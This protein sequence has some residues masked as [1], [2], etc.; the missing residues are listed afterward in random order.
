MVNS[1]RPNSLYSKSRPTNPKPH[2][3]WTTKRVP[4]RAMNAA[5]QGKRTNYSGSGAELDLRDAHSL[6]AISGTAHT[7]HN[8]I[9]PHSASCVEFA[10]RRQ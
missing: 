10:G 6:V 8:W 2:S 3:D 9:I 5:P 4:L 7:E 1:P